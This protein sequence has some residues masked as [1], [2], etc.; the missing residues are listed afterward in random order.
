M[1]LFKIVVQMSPSSFVHF[2]STK[3]KNAISQPL[4]HKKIKNTQTYTH[5]EGTLP[6]HHG[7]WEATTLKKFIP[8][9]RGEIAAMDDG[10]HAAQLQDK[11]QIG[12]EL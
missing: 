7:C 2:P 6:L 3:E 10:S 11:D 4:V 1:L 8:R 5:K 9:L 12:E